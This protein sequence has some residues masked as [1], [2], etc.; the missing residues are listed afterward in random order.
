M[1]S[2]VKEKHLKW[3]IIA[4]IF[5]LFTVFV[6]LLNVK[7]NTKY[8]ELTKELKS[9]QII[10]GTVDVQGKGV[11]ITLTDSKN[12]SNN[13]I[14]DKV[15]YLVHDQDI[16]YIVHELENAGAETISIN[17]ER[18]NT[19]SNIKAKGMKIKINEHEY[20][21]PFVIKAIGDPDSLESILKSAENELNIRKDMFGIGVEIKKSDKIFIPK[22][23]GNIKFKYA[24]PV[25]K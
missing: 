10:A 17:D 25:T 6:S 3:S 11:I 9:N 21:P 22:Y 24:Q 19:L 1:S 13:P 16:I 2:M 18:L 12:F 23:N 20:E 15:N 4:I 7:N 14:E 8:N 5:I